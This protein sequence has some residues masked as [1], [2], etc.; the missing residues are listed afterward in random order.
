MGPEILVFG[1]F[2]LVA[3][4]MIAY[5]VV[6]AVLAGMINEM[7]TSFLFPGVG[8]QWATIMSVGCLPL[9][10]ILFYFLVRVQLPMLRIYIRERGALGMR[11]SEMGSAE[12]WRTLKSYLGHVGRDVRSLLTRRNK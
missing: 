2:L 7:I 4:V 5:V 8:D 9:G 12:A 10:A 6:L 3:A 11:H 1:P